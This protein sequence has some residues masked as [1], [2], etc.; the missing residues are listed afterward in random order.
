MLLH[1]KARAG[2]GLNLGAY[3]EFIVELRRRKV[4]GLHPAHGEHHAILFTHGVLIDPQLPHPITSRA[5]YILEIVRIID[6]P[7]HVGVFIVNADRKSMGHAPVLGAARKAGNPRLSLFP[8]Y[9]RRRRAI[10][11]D[12][13]L[14]ARGGRVGAPAKA[15]QRSGYS[16]SSS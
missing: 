9:S 2:H 16:A 12:P 10:R 13:L 4:I 1:H 11:L 15:A 14:R 8:K 3:L 5:L 7:R 6:D